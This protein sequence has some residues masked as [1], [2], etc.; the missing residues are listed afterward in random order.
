MHPHQVI[1]FP[2][3]FPQPRYGVQIH[4]HGGVALA[5]LR[6]GCRVIGFPEVIGSQHDLPGQRPPLRTRH[7]KPGVVRTQGFQHGH[8]LAHG[9]RPEIIPG[10][11][12]GEN[13][14]QLRE[15]LPSPLRFI[16]KF[17]A[18]RL[19]FACLATPR[20]GETRP[21]LR[22]RACDVDHNGAIIGDRLQ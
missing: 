12:F 14:V 11:R 22:I 20:L 16:A 21:D 10:G 4:E 8:V 7:E 18:F 13:G 6:T 9:C 17:Q 3:G 15:N 5:S 2:P 1:S 19:G